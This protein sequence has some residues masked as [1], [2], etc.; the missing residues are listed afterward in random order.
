M[1]DHLLL[2]FLGGAGWGRTQDWFPAPTWFITSIANSSSRGFDASWPP[3]TLHT[4]GTQAHMQAKNTHRH[5]I[6]KV[7]LHFC[8]SRKKLRFFCPCVDYKVLSATH[9]RLYC[10]LFFFHF[11]F[12]GFFCCWWQW[13]LLCFQILLHNFFSLS[14]KSLTTSSLIYS[15]IHGTHNS[16]ALV[17]GC[18]FNFCVS[19]Y[20]RTLEYFFYFEAVI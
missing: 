13:F 10:H 16:L 1:P 3:Q 7:R 20:L 6:V 8:K 14:C 15:G 9:L 18:G 2:F 12:R 17:L 11:W 4:R 19:L 5:K